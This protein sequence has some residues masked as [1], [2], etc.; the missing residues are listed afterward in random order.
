VSAPTDTTVAQETWVGR[1]LE[2]FEDEALLRGAGRFLD[3]LDPAPGAHHAAV[4]RS[5][6][7]HARIVRLDTTRA[8]RMPGVTGVL[9]GADVVELSRPFPAACRTEIP[10]Y[11]A[12][13]ETTRYVGEPL[14]VVVARDRYVAEDALDAI[15]VELDPLPPLMDAREAAAA[16]GPSLVSDRRFTYGDPDAAFARA[17]VVVRERFTFPR[18]TCAPIECA[19]VVARWD[20][21]EESLTA[22]TNFQGPFTLHSVAAAALKLPGAKLRLVTPPDSGGS[23]GVKAA[24]YAAV[25]LMGLASRRLGVPVR[26]IEDR[27]EQLAAGGASTE[28]TTEIE[29]A[30]SADGELLGLRLD[31]I[32]D[33][34]A[35]VRAPEPATLYRMHGALTGAYRVRNLAVRN[36]V[37]LTN[38]APTTLNRGFGG[39][40]HYL[41]IE[42]SMGLAARRLGLDPAE[43]ARRNLIASDAFPYTT[44][45]GGLY[46]SGD[47]EGCL[48]DALELFDYDRRRAERDSARAQGRLVG[49]GLAC[50]VEPSI[51]NMGYVTLVETAE[52]RADALPKSGNAEGASVAINPNGGITVRMSTTPQGQGHATVARQVAADVLGVTPGDVHVVTEVDTATSPWTVSSGAYSSRFSGV[53]AGAVLRAADKVAGKLRLL[54]AAQLRCDPD[55]VVLADGRAALAHDPETS[56]SLRRLVGAAH[57]NPHGLPD[58]VEPGLH[59]VA[60]CGAEELPPPDGEDRIV[61][62]GENGF[63]V[64]VVMVE[65][66][67]E[68]GRVRVLDYV[69]VHDAGRLLNPRLA[70]GQVQGGFAHGV[71][72]ALQERIAYG[73]DGELLTPTLKEYLLATPLDLPTPRMGHR[74]TP[75]PLT[76]LGAKGLGEGTT[77]SAPVAL[78]NAVTDALGAERAVGLPLTPSRVW[79]RIA[80]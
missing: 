22:W 46:A 80:P 44:P 18:W 69:S 74:E 51:S 67:R 10:C 56:V 7:A 68:T 24:V 79:E 31:V 53:G 59:A 70:A 54:A 4:L 42:G 28:R 57:W 30:F 78:Q 26:W 5:S 39:P 73:A 52:D 49:I 20:P 34:G 33:V 38:R 16:P 9:T 11:A 63:V 77:M 50:V 45:T 1:P 65:V 58:G 71:G 13:H 23:F 29:A 3:D 66:E 2:R 6:E 62:S 48:D 8:L 40:Q 75:S 60:F 32:E 17:D 35:Y 37:V 14:A 12:A 43:L 47:Y 21:G 15:E 27:R 72:A 61:A 64:D 76:P 41:P 55:D 25:V 19:G 36:R